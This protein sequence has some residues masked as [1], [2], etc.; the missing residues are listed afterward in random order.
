MSHRPITRAIAVV[1]ALLLTLA[2]AMHQADAAFVIGA[3]PHA[4]GFGS[5]THLRQGAGDTSAHHD[6]AGLPDHH[7]LAGLCIAMAG[8]MLPEGCG[9]SISEPAVDWD[10]A[11]AAIPGFLPPK[12]PDPPPR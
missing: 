5:A 1:V 8:V 2:G 10:D 12:V 6:Q 3:G 11:A 4:H 9:V 7:P